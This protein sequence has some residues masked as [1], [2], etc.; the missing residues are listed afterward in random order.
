[1]SME[2]H[3]V[4]CGHNR[5]NHMSFSDKTDCDFPDCNCHEFRIWKYTSYNDMLDA[6]I[7]RLEK[8]IDR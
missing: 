6:K 7:Q 5:E 3:C 8:D 4:D 1:M 2:D